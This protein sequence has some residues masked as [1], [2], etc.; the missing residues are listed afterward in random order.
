MAARQPLPVRPDNGHRQT[1]PAGRDAGQRI[2]I[3]NHKIKFNAGNPTGYGVPL[4]GA[5]GG[6]DCTIPREGSEMTLATEI[7][8]RL[9]GIAEPVTHEQL[10]R[11]GG[12]P[13]FHPPGKDADNQVRHGEAPTTR[14]VA[15][16]PWW[17]RF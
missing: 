7:L 3:P 1:S 9:V 2:V 13:Q 12:N 11:L 15:I 10:G 16:E 8:A 6:I 4:I 14:R 17:F 5:D